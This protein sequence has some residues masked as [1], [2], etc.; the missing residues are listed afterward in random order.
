MRRLKSLF[1]ALAV[2]ALSAGI[3]L[4]ARQMPQQAGPGLQRASDASGKAV[5]LGHDASAGA[6]EQDGPDAGD[7]TG[8]QADQS[9][10]IP[11]ADAP[12]ADAP[13]ADAPTDTHGAVVS[14][15]AQGTTPDGWANH[16]AYVSAVAHGD[17]QP[18]DPAPAEAVANGGR[19][20]KAGKAPHPTKPDHATNLDH[21]SKPK[22]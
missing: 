11:V 3:A 19:M 6:D 9:E 5:P 13:D 4:A 21:G 10:D 12:D 17:V 16:G 8:D 18:G 1:I 7:G 2:L 15:A 20:P 14:E 22:G